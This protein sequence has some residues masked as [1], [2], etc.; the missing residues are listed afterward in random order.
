M[1][2]PQPAVGA[3]V[4]AAGR[5]ER[6]GGVVKPWAPITDPSGRSRPLLSYP[7]AAFQACEAVDAVVLV[8][9]ADAVE[10]AQALLRDD[11]LD[12]VLAVVPG[13]AR[14]QDS[15]RAGLDALGRCEW[16]VVHD[17]AR[18]LVTPELIERGI[19]A[20]GGT[21]ASCCAILAPDTVKEAE[22]CRVVRTLDRSRLWLAQTPQVFRYDVLL[23]AHDRF[24][25]DATD[26]A[27]MAEALG[28][29]VRLYQG[30]P[31]N[32]KV[33]TP[34]DLKV[35]QALLRSGG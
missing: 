33:T 21:G 12:K 27:S 22:D 25:G 26:D 5:S 34:D 8:V 1:A 30:S 4:V 9:A 6:M 28:I 19:E 14:R 35:V 18:P 17:G 15:V 7:V 20:A 32:L 11:G 31:R 16:I 10:R 3:I 29:D 23:E 24:E 2:A 13:G